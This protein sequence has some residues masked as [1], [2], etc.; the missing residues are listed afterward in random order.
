MTGA[1]SAAFNITPGA[2][3]VLVFTAQPSS[4]IAGAAITPAVVVTARDNHG[5]TATAFTG[6]ITVAIGTNPGDGTLSGTT[7]VAAAAGVATFGGLSINLAGNGYT[8]A[9]T[10]TGPTG[11]TS[12][13]FNI[14]PG[15]ASATQST[16]SAAPS[17]IA[18]SSGASASTITVTARDQFSNVIQG[19]TVVLAATGAENTLSQPSGTTNG[20]GVATGTLSSTHAETKTVSATINAVAITQ[21]ATITVTPAAPSAALTTVSA[22]PT[23]IPASLGTATSTITVTARDP[24]NNVIQGATVVLDATGAGNTLMQPSGPTNSSGV[25]TGTLS[26]FVAGTKTV[27]ATVNAVDITQTATV[28][29]TPLTEA[30]ATQSSLVSTPGS[31]VASNGATVSTITVTARDQFDNLIQGATVVLAATGG[32]NTLTQPGATNAGGVAIG[33]LSSDDAE[34]KTVSATINGVGITQTTA[35]TV[36]PAAAATLVFT[37]QPSLAT[38]IT[39]IAPPVTVLVR[40]AFGNTVTGFAG[41][42]TMTIQ[43]DASLL[44]DATLTGTNPATVV[45]GVAAFPNLRINRL[46]VGY[47][48]RATAGVLFAISATFTVL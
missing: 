32:G 47:T 13:A 18:A 46:G 2:A 29:V 31:I 28:T 17:S 25:T 26:S 7:A 24:F 10:A 38:T 39:D 43:N 45:D 6:T 44:S 9:A 34:T 36:I 5:N 37:Q 19:A 33:S 35:V 12:A 16:V 42:V 40:D 22:A 30:S 41:T 15:A 1:T 4:E 20:S 14:T 23:S 3:S 8:L 27:S 48:L 21:T 11:A